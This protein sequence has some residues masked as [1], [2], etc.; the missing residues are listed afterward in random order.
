MM[1][2]L[3]CASRCALSTIRLAGNSSSA[4]TLI[5]RNLD[6][7]RNAHAFCT[8]P[9]DRLC[10]LAHFRRGSG[11]PQLSRLWPVF[12]MALFDW[13]PRRIQFQCLIQ[14][15]IAQRRV[16]FARTST[17]AIGCARYV[18]WVERLSPTS[19]A[20]RDYLRM[21]GS[22]GPATAIALA[23]RIGPAPRS[24]PTAREIGPV[25]ITLRG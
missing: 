21:N 4:V 16:E 25:E 12:G 13:P 15:F 18:V 10:R 2:A 22:A 3:R 5:S 24:E 6:W 17:T 11:F 14:Q 1:T 7:A 20:W 23:C 8:A 19:P 9:I